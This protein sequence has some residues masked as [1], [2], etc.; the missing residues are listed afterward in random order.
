MD[1]SFRINNGL[2]MACELLRD[3]SELGLPAR[4]RQRCAQ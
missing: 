3:I 4:R 1:N 2:R